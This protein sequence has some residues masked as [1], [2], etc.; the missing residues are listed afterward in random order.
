LTWLEPLSGRSSGSWQSLHLAETRLRLYSGGIEGLQ[1]ALTEM[2]KESRRRGIVD[3]RTYEAS[4]LLVHLCTSRGESPADW[5]GPDL[6]GGQLFPDDQLFEL[7]RI[8]SRVRHG[9]RFPLA[10]VESRAPQPEIR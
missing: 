6:P 2:L 1:P 7:R 9:E 10:P 5:A 3:R 4:E 8:R